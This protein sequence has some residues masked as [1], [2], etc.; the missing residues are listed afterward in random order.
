MSKSALIGYTGFVGSNIK[1]E[2]DFTDLYN[3]KNIDDIDGKEYDLVVSAATYA[4]MWKINANP[5]ED[6][7]RISSLMEHLKTVKAKQFV[8]ISTICVFKDPVDGFTEDTP[9][10]LQNLPPYGMHRYKLEQFV[11]KQFPHVLIVRLPGLFGAGI[12]KNIIFDLIH[13]NNVDRIHK[14]ASVQYYNLAHL[15]DDIQTALKNNIGLLHLSVEPTTTEEVAQ[16]AFGKEFTNAPADVHPKTFDFKSKHAGL[17]HG[18]NG[19]LYSKQQSLEDIKNF[20]AS[21]GATS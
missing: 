18:T 7:A 6:W 1:A 17:F 10:D 15:W 20:V 16:A 5:E 3:T 2:H 11:K 8:L 13:D 21:E 12:K 4:E 14:D 9:V 19:Y